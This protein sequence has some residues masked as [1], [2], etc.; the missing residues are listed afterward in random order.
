MSSVRE[1]VETKVRDLGFKDIK[2]TWNDEWLTRTLSMT[3]PVQQEAAMKQA[4]ESILN[5][6]T[7][8]EA[9]EFEEITP[10]QLEEL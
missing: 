7:K 1:Q 3:D 5:V 9:G 8:Y 10:E 2:F 4:L 6:L